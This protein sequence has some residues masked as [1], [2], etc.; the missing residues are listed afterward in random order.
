MKY[1]KI[2][3]YGLAA[4]GIILLASVMRVTLIAQGWPL[5]SSDEGTIGLM[6]LHIAY[7]GAHPI[8]YYGQN[9]MGSLEAFIAAP[10]FHLFGPSLF[11]VRLGMA[12]L[13]ALFLVCMYLLVRL[14]YSKNFALVSLV[15]LSLGSDQVLLRELRAI[16]G[17]GE[18]TFFGA[19][20][21]LLA[22]WIALSYSDANSTI[23]RRR[24]RG[25]AYGGWGLA[26]GLG[27]WSDLLIAPFVLVSAVFIF[28]FCR[29][30]LRTRATIYLLLGFVI[31]AAPLLYY[32][33]TSPLDNSLAIF[34][35]LHRGGAVSEVAGPFPIV[36]QIMGTFL[37][38][39][40]YATNAHPLCSQ[41]DFSPFG[42]QGPHFLQ[43]VL[44]Q[45]LWGTGFF[46]LWLLAVV[47]AARVAWSCWR[48]QRTPGETEETRSAEQRHT[49]VLE[50]ARLMVLA[51]AGLI[52]LSYMLSPVAALGPWTT[53][54][55]LFGLLAA[56]P[57]LLWP[58]WRGIAARSKPA[59]P[60][61]S[62]EPAPR[63][64]VRNLALSLPGWLLLLLIG[65]VFVAGTIGAFGA[66]P[67]VQRFNQQQDALI[68]DLQ[69]IGQRHIYAGYW[70]CNQLTFQSQERVICAVLD[71]HLRPGFDRYLPYRATVN[72]DPHAAYVFLLNDSR[73]DDPQ[74]ATFEQWSARS[75]GHY[76][77]YLFEGYAVYVPQL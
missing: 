69:G 7:Q 70:I 54:R 63:Q 74:A 41:G 1:L 3:P 14:L 73:G 36:Q 52:L 76:R 34:L 58:L 22:A 65:S 27:L 19:L 2:E 51:S 5:T 55:Y 49:L 57:A 30:E 35:S 16:G 56:V 13:F 24:L 23:G 6:A 18:T 20:L 62:G 10:L 45:G 46:A 29:R 31:G 71:T 40:P 47:L 68:H 37:V 9:Y 72:A 53:W 43:C 4:S 67:T 15:L 48:R 26:A 12:L 44:F 25:L 42:P 75:G 11:A 21:L 59:E 32:N 33:I 61:S 50:A 64:P 66:V 60:V 77:R 8:F 28:L 39:I 17:Y 38:A